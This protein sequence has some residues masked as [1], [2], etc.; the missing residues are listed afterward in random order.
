MMKCLE[1]RIYVEQLQSF[2]VHVVTARQSQILN[3]TA[4][5]NR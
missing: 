3:I 5:D 1:E 4:G 2:G